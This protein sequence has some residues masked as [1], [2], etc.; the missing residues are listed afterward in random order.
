MRLKI[1]VDEVWPVFYLE[2]GITNAYNEV[3][4]NEDFYKQYLAL[5]D[6]YN[7][8]QKQLKVLYDNQRAEREKRVRKDLA[9]QPT[10]SNSDSE[11]S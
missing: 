9:S 8:C 11:T 7:L 2:E 5:M 6:V 1:S 10:P 4:V 3:D